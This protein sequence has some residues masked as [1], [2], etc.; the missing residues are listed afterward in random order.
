[1]GKNIC[2]QIKKNLGVSIFHICLGKH[3][4]LIIILL[5]VISNRHTAYGTYSPLEITLKQFCL[6]ISQQQ[7]RAKN[8]IK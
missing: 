4:T 7:N 3:K 2:C 8:R 5:H 6:P 1:M